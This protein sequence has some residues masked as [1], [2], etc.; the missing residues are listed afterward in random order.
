MVTSSPHNFLRVLMLPLKEIDNSLPQSGKIID[1]GCG[2]GIIADY[3]ANKKARFV[4]G[5]D[6]D[7]KRLKKTAKKNLVF[8][9]ADIRKFKLDEIDGAVISDVL[10]HMDFKDQKS[11]LKNIAKGL[12]KDGVLVIKEIDTGEFIRSRLSRFW[13]FVFYPRDKIHFNDA[14]KL[15]KFLESLGLEVTIKRPTRLFP[16]STTLFVCKK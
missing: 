16:G 1:L 8:H 9:L 7:E 6:V 11:L 4:V 10:H 5:V 12:K 3:L 14:N 2:E 15:K 13:D